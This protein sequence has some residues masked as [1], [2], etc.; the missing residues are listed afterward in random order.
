LDLFLQTLNVGIVLEDDELIGHGLHFHSMAC[1]LQDML[2]SLLEQ[3]LDIV[4]LEML[5]VFRKALL[6]DVHAGTKGL[7]GSC[8]LLALHEA[9]GHIVES[10]SGTIVVASF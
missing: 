7:A 8:I 4:D 2:L 10:Q 3:D 1:Q 5:L 9:D 6:E